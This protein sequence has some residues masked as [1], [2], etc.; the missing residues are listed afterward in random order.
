MAKTVSGLLAHCK[1]AKDW[2]YVYGMKGSIMSLKQYDYLKSMYGSMVWNSDKTKV[3]SMC[4]DCSGLISS[5]TGILRG[6]SNY[7]DTATAVVSL[8]ELKS[9]WNKYIGWGLWLKGHIG[10]VS[11]TEGYYYAMDGSARNWAHRPLKDNSWT[12]V[13]KLCD[14]D[15]SSPVITKPSP[16][17]STP[18]KSDIDVYYMSYVGGKWLGAIT[19]CEGFSGI[20]NKP[21][22][23]F[24]AHSSKGFIRYRV[25][26]LGA[27]S[28]DNFKNSSSVVNSNGYGGDGK[29][30]I[31]GIQMEIRNV[32]GYN[33]MYRVS[34]KGSTSYLPWVTNYND[35]EDGYAGIF[36]KDIDKIQIKI[37]KK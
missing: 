28:W 5:Y 30:H 6:S 13:I 16:I 15:Y 14:I 35:T 11:D 3:G 7:K 17:T 23:A 22:T 34:L 31:D 37:V 2:K 24:T 27:K 10:V 18:S 25:H 19:N 36:G 21:I 20:E 26:R 29:T 12:H 33:I 32:P 9:N 8:T 4:C 1:A